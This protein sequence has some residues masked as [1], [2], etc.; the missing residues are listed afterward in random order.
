MVELV[1]EFAL[2]FVWEI[3]LELFVKQ[4]ALEEAALEEVVL[5][6]VV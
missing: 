3:V 2:K 1:L 5:G 6:Q 4:V